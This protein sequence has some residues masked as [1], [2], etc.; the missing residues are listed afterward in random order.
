MTQFT[1]LNLSR[2]FTR[3]QKNV[4]KPK[5]YPS[6][7]IRVR[8]KGH[9]NGRLSARTLLGERGQGRSAKRVVI[10]RSRLRAFPRMSEQTACFGCRPNSNC[11]ASKRSPCAS[12]LPPLPQR[13]ARVACHHPPPASR[14]GRGRGWGEGAGAADEVANNLPRPSRPGQFCSE[15]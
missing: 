5:P 8:D 2:T 6:P 12:V 4:G 14:V 13:L 15:E 10:Y 9:C 3:I 1:A 11:A 7:P